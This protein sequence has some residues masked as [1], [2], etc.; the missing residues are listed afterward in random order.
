[1]L[2]KKAADQVWND[3]SSAHQIGL[4]NINHNGAP[5]SINITREYGRIEMAALRAQC[6]R[7][8]I[9]ED[10]QHRVHQNNQML[11]ACIWELLMWRTQQ[12]LAQYEDEYTFNG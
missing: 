6:K 8:M 9:G 10:S 11:Q 12:R 1:M 4:F 3:A 2:D 5:T 7:F